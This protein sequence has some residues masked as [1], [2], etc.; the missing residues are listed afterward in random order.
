MEYMPLIAAVQLAKKLDATPILETILSNF[1]S[2]V[3]G[4]ALFTR[5]VKKALERSTKQ[6]YISAL[7][8]ELL[9]NFSLTSFLITAT[10]KNIHN[11]QATKFNNMLASY[12]YQTT[13]LR[14]AVFKENFG[15]DFHLRLAML[16]SLFETFN[17]ATEQKSPLESDK[18]T[19]WISEL[20][21]NAH[22]I[23]EAIKV[24]FKEVINPNIQK[25]RLNITP[26][27]EQTFL[28]LDQLTEKN[29][30]I[31]PWFGYLMEDIRIHEEAPLP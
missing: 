31:T 5:P 17:K 12:K 14:E 20:Q 6:K 13:A 25:L 15:I 22:F 19:D 8:A 9:V 29:M 30:K 24:A 3:V 7:I 11:S 21:R 10:Q 18:Y 26:V 4:F 1:L 27:L 23:K 2:A 28:D 16:L